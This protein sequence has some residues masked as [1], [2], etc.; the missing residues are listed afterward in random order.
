M[1]ASHRLLQ[2]ILSKTAESFPEKVAI[3]QD[4]QTITYGELDKLSSRFASVLIDLGVNKGD[5]V[6]IFLGNRPQFVIAYF[7]VLKAGAVVTVVSPLHKEL[8]VE[9]QLCDSGAQSIVVFESLYHI[10]ER[11]MD[12]TLL[13]NVIVTGGGV[14]EGYFK[15]SDVG[16]GSNVFDFWDLIEKS[17]VDSRNFR[18]VSESDLAVLQYTSGTSGVPK[19]VMLSHV[20]LVSNVSFFTSWIKGVVD[21]VFLSVLPFFHVY[22]MTTSMLVPISLGAELVLLSRFDPVECLRV[23]E[24]CRVSVFCGSPFMFNGLFRVEFEGYDLSSIRVCISGAS[25]LSVDVQERFMRAGVFLVEGYGLTEASPVTHCTP[26]DRSIG[27]V[28]RG[29]VGLALSGTEARVVDVET[30]CSVLGVGKSGELCVRGLQVML[31]YWRD[32]VESARVL[33]DGWLFTGDI[34]YMD[35]DGYLYIVGR[36]KD[37]IKCKDVSICPRELEDILYEHSAVKSCVVVGKSD[38]I[39]GEVPKAFVVLKDSVKVSSGELIEFVNCKV[40][41]YKA[42][43]EVELCNELPHNLGDKVLGVF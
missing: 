20:N 4:N 8:E 6:A 23:I 40:A 13:K 31:G 41:S 36:K 12:K 37:L 11:V 21:D 3:R 33:R 27:S 5:I 32:P 1:G 35:S 30:G 43:V 29:S 2:V 26:I 28:K 15:A 17:V 34:A 14:G 38:K 10:I 39:Q 16:M 25:H 22:G 24:H 18:F 42:L 9:R 19:G 7:G